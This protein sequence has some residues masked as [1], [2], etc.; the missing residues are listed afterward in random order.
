M[1]PAAKKR[2]NQRT[3]IE[4]EIRF[5]SCML[6]VEILKPRQLTNVRAEPVYAAGAD[7]A[8]RVEH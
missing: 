3:L 4:P 2:N 6:K 1:G 5:R 7:W 8:T